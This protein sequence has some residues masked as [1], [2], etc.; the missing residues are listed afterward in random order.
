MRRLVGLLLCLAAALMCVIP[1]SASQE[2]REYTLTFAGDCTFGCTPTTYYAQL[3]FVKTVG[4]DYGYP[5]RSVLPWFEEDDLTVV[6]LEGPLTLSNTLIKK[7]FTF[8]GPPDFVNILTQ[9]CVE[10]V[11]L[12]NNHT[13]DYGRTGYQE[14][15]ATLEEADVSYVEPD[16]YTL[17]PLNDSFTVGLYGCVF[18]YPTYEELE[19]I[20]SEM[21]EQGADLIV[22]LPHWGVENTYEPTPQQVQTGHDA[23]DAGANMVCGAHP[24]VLQPMER[25]GDGIIFYSLGNFAFGGNS[26]P[27][28]YDTALISQK[29][30]VSEDGA[31]SLGDT[32][33]IPACVSSVANRNDYQP[34]PYETGSEGY[35]R[36]MEKLGWPLEAPQ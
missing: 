24:H 14:T 27:N 19:R 4:D 23:I 9:G 28:D 11:T 21:Q 30:L 6:N 34:T 2:E 18:R 33:P 7:R 5:F 16:C 36:T 15:L 31:I 8:K 35:L 3:G 12:A 22:F 25:Y 26:D 13:M 17:I 1:V 20:F 29:V 32:T 10:A